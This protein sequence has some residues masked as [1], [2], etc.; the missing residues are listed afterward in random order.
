MQRLARAV[1]NDRMILEELEFAGI[2]A[3]EIDRKVQDDIPA[4]VA[5]R[6][7]GFLFRRYTDEWRVEGNMPLAKALVLHSHPDNRPN[8]GV[9]RPEPASCRPRN[10]QI[11]VPRNLKSAEDFYKITVYKDEQGT[12]LEPL[13]RRIQSDRV[14]ALVY[15]EE[16]AGR[17]S[18]RFV[19][20]PS[21]HGQPYITG[22]SILYLEGLRLFAQ[23][24]RVQG[25]AGA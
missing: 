4:A 24:L 7:G 13:N 10:R 3:I 19:D 1:S 23:F 15:G 2:P 11:I 21:A 9:A 5:G 8:V 12:T 14:R 6:L 16:V 20:N 18:V 25:L 17:P 22:Y